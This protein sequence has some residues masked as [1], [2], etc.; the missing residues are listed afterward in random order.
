[1]GFK[2][3]NKHWGHPAAYIITL[4]KKIRQTGWSNSVNE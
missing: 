3:F 4:S 1:L 2:W